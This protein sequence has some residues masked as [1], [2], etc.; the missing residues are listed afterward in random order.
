MQQTIHRWALLWREGPRACP[1]LQEYFLFDVGRPLLFDTRREARE[2]ATGNYGY[3]RSRPDLRAAPH[4]WRMPQA[5]RVTV[6]IRQ[7]GE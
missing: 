7:E 4:F 6:T 2:W 5:V 3:I 1:V